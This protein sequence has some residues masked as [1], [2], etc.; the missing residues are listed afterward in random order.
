MNGKS[1]PPWG[2]TL[3]ALGFAAFI[4]M[5]AL[6]VRRNRGVRRTLFSFPYGLWIV[7]FTLIPLFLIGYYAF[8]DR[9]GADA[10]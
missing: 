10:S 3:M 1:I 5:I 2:M 6:N 9:L 7:L 4:G 8:T